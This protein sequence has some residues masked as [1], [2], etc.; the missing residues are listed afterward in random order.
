MLR[1]LL[2]RNNQLLTCDVIPLGRHGFGV[3]VVPHWDLSASV[4]EQYASAVAAVRRHTELSW[5][6]RQIGWQ[7]VL[8]N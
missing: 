2:S 8:E 6:F 1:A 4:I 5:R 7:R 3:Q